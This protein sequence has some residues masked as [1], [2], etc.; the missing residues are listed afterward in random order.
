MLK[1]SV[2]ISKPFCFKKGKQIENELPSL[3]NFSPFLHLSFQ[4]ISA[5]ITKN[6]I[7][8]SIKCARLEKLNRCFGEEYRLNLQGRIVGQ[9][10]N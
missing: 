5:V 1:R 2:V 4:F 3:R 8:W 6:F 7:F 9:P 10:R